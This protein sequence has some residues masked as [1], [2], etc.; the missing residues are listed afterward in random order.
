MTRKY[1]GTG[2]GLAISQRLCWMLGGEITVVSALG[3]GTTCTVRL[4][5]AAVGSLLDSQE[6]GAGNEISW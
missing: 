2:L 5:A 4:P 3:H 1:G 6:R